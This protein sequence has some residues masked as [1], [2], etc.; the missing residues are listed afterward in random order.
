MGP[1]TPPLPGLD[2]NCIT[3]KPI[4][5]KS[6]PKGSRALKESWSG[7]R[8]LSRSSTST[9]A[10][11]NVSISPSEAFYQL[12]TSIKYTR[13]GV[14][15]DDD[16][17]YSPWTVCDERFGAVA[18]YDKGLGSS[19]GHLIVIESENANANMRGTGLGIEIGTEREIGSG[20]GGSGL[21]IAIANG[22]G[23]WITIDGIIMG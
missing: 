22:K 2:T 9:T 8:N 15:L 11:A 1:L 14:A 5:H 7:S 18:Q 4:L 13:I 21:V 23:I 17:V 3:M 6:P 19:D 12:A 10:T 20:T 16:A